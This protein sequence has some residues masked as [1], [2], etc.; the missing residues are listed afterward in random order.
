MATNENHYNSEEEEMM[1]AETGQPAQ[2][3]TTHMRS[4]R[5][6]NDLGAELRALA[7]EE[8]RTQTAIILEAVRRLLAE[9]RVS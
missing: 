9:R 8:Q 6:P 5:M 2:R 4:V 3:M 1:I 7:A